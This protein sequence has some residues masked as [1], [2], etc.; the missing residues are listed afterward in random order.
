[1]LQKREKVFISYSHLDDVWLS[2]L[3]VFL[4]PL[5]RRLG[6]EIWD[7]TRIEAGSIWRDIVIDAIATAKVAVLLVTANFLASDFIANEELPPL[8]S[9]AEKEG[10]TILPIIIGHSDFDDTPE[11]SQFQAVNNPR[12]PLKTLTEGEQEEIFLDVSRRIKSILSEEQIAE[13]IPATPE[14][15][16]SGENF[17]SN[18][19]QAFIKIWQLLIGLATSG[20]SLWNEVTNENLSDFV[21]RLNEAEENI[22]EAGL[23]FSKKDFDSLKQL[24][25]VATFYSDGKQTL[26]KLYQ[27]P[28]FKIDVAP[29]GRV[30]G[31]N[32]RKRE[33]I[34]NQIKKNENWL[35]QYKSLLSEIRES[36]HT[37][38]Q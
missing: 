20:Q 5:E 23:F 10:A 27:E 33:E 12:R 26:F 28:V 18:K 7:D 3:R 15:L 16:P 11:L 6:I 31:L 37:N 9:A 8:L 35:N 1:M 22:W 17:P 25:E 21:K 38:F 4:K 2:R 34:K 13:N 36:L 14:K 30:M 32:D 29:T 24:L 19:R